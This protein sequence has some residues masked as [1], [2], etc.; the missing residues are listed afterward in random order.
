MDNSSEITMA[1]DTTAGT[2]SINNDVQQT[3]TKA[4][5]TTQ[6]RR[7]GKCMVLALLQIVIYMEMGFAKLSAIFHII[8]ENIEFQFFFFQVLQYFELSSFALALRLINLQYQD[9]QSF[10]IICYLISE[11]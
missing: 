8:V 1:I 7:T 2:T 5:Y 4:I 6:G 10:V 11:K 3:T 9:A